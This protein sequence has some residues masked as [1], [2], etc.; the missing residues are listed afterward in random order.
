M[1]SEILE[2]IFSYC[3]MSLANFRLKTTAVNYLQRLLSSQLGGKSHWYLVQLEGTKILF[4][5]PSRI[6]LAHCL[7]FVETGKKN[8]LAH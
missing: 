3:V 4:E 5:V 1:P 7:K 8:E 2:N 6:C